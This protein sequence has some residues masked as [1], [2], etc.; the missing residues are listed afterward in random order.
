MI[1][2][3]WTQRQLEVAVWAETLVAV[4]LA[5]TFL[6]MFFVGIGGPWILF[7]IG[8]LGIVGFGIYVYQSLLRIPQEIRVL[9]EVLGAYFK[10]VGPGLHWIPW[11]T[12][13]ARAHVSIQTQRYPLFKEP[14]W[15]DFQDGSA[16]PRQAFAYVRM[17]NR[18]EEFRYQHDIQGRVQQDRHLRDYIDRD[19]AYRMVYAVRN[20]KEA[21]ISL[22]ESSVRSYL[23]SLTIQEALQKGGA[24]YNIAPEL[25]NY[26]ELRAVLMNWGLVL[27]KIV[28]GDFN[29]SET[30]IKL[31]ESVHK[32]RQEAKA[33]QFIVDRRS[34]E[35]AGVIVKSLSQATG[36]TIS[37]IKEELAEN[38]ETKEQLMAFVQDIISRDISIRAGALTDIR[39]SGGSSLQEALVQAIAA[40]KTVHSQ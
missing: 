2:M 28:V 22:L 18:E 1:E 25:E 14:V 19:P 35:I 27:E 33:A 21:V 3:E 23:N 15:I 29:L 5:F 34:K 7:A 40:F 36:K 31:R 10:T 38:A 8:L 11:I 24:G 13:A 9:E 30:I 37:Q 20:I 16:S 4:I 39:V 17:M 6:I 12:G 32:A 26:E